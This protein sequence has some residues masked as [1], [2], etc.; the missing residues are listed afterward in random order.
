MTQALAEK[1][2]HIGPFEYKKVAS[3]PLSEQFS[4]M[5]EPL[6]PKKKKQR[7][8]SKSQDREMGETE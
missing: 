1:L 3:A 8:Q 2:E 6:W 5:A 4:G 7:H